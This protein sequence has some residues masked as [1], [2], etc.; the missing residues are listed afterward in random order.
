MFYVVGEHKGMVAYYCGWW[1]PY[2]EA[3]L[4]NT[5]FGAKKMKRA[6]ANRVRRRLEN[7]EI[8][9]GKWKLVSA[10]CIDQ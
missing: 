9:G 7:P 5:I 6:N 10:T 2:G 8:W 1:H 3:L 4:S